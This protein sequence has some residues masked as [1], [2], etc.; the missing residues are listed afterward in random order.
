[1]P[2]KDKIQTF[3]LVGMEIRRMKTG[4][5]LI[6][7]PKYLASPN[8]TIACIDKG[9]IVDRA[10]LIQLITILQKAMKQLNTVSVQGSGL[11]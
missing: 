3:P 10:A 4:D 2:N 8:N 9:F 11:H 5:S 1:M 7:T 6:L